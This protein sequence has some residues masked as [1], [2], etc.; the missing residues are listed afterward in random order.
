VAG[1][2]SSPAG[3]NLGF[4]FVMVNEETGAIPGV[5]VSPGTEPIE[6]SCGLANKPSQG[7]T[8]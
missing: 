5:G 3:W 8:V 6:I 2:G 1:T 4:G 7:G